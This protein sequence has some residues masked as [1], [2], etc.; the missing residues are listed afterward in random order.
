MVS[1]FFVPCL[2]KAILYRRSAGYFTSA[3]LALAARG[4]A[5]LVSRGGRMQLVVSPYLEP[6]DIEALQRAKERPSEA[7][8]TIVS[9]DLVEIEDS[10]MRDRLNA[11][12]WLAASELLEIRL[13]LRLDDH[14][15]ISRGLYHEKVG[16]FT[17]NENN[18]V[19]FSGSSNE[20][21]GGLVENF[22]CIEVFRSWN[23]PDG[24]IP[25]KLRDFKALWENSTPGLR[26]IEFS[27][28]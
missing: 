2:Q 13:A 15:Q 18:H 26:V 1:D 24:R 25:E 16:I 27:N 6:Q 17:D 3:G 5:S 21:A 11:L 4:V 9:R 22:E 10:L 28:A 20:T 14:G 19:A 23:D 12:A 8:A 7:L